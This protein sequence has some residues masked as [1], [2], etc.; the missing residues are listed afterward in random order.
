MVC[1]TTAEE[2]HK[3]KTVKELST[4]FCVEE[5]TVKARL[6][7]L[8]LD[9]QHMIKRIYRK[10]KAVISRKPNSSANV[11]KFVLDDD[12]RKILYLYSIRRPLRKYLKAD[13]IKAKKDSLK[14][15]EFI[16]K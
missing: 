12:A 8:G 9:E 11:K 5:S 4:I 13:E 2:Y 14:D 6:K 1:F 16:R 7:Q 10:I 15:H 3:G